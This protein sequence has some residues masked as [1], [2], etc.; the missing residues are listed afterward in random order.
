MWD[1]SSVPAGATMTRSVSN[2]QVERSQ[3]DT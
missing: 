2:K 1:V 3:G